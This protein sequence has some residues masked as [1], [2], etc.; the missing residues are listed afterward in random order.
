[1]TFIQYLCTHKPECIA[2]IYVYNHPCTFLF[3]HCTFLF[4]FHHL[5]HQFCCSPKFVYWVKHLSP[6]VLMFSWSRMSCFILLIQ[7]VGSA[8][9]HLSE[10]YC[11]QTNIKL[12]YNLWFKL[13][14]NV[15]CSFPLTF[16]WKHYHWPWENFQGNADVSQVSSMRLLLTSDSQIF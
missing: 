2:H 4:G 9:P 1:M 5:F 15:R 13:C 7:I 11:C 8:P 6:I 16:L 14:S 3:H 10:L 12:W